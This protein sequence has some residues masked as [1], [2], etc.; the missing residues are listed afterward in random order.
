MTLPLD[1]A[2]G[3][4]PD[5]EAERHTEISRDALRNARRELAQ[6]DLMQ[7]SE[8]AWGAAAH[9][10]KATA[11][12]R[13]WFSE[14][15]WKLQR[16]TEIITIELKDADIIG[17]YYTARHA[18]FNFYGH[19]YDAQGVGLAIDAAENLVAKLEPTLAPDYSPPY[20]DATTAAK[21]RSLEQPTSALDRNRLEN[22]RPPM[23]ERP[24]AASPTPAS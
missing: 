24:P 13:R 22:G 15:D 9:A 17:S 7:A 19:L 10:V 20:V 14:A 18:H 4:S 8:K 1:T 16:A 12:K 3:P 11:E 21:I 23:E 6:G 2:P 5:A